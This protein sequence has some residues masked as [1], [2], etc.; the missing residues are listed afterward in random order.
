LFLVTGAIIA[1][2]Q[3]LPYI[4]GYQLANAFLVIASVALG[5]TVLATTGRGIIAK[6]AGLAYLAGIIFLMWDHTWVPAVLSIMAGSVM[7]GVGSL[8]EGKPRRWIGAL[9][10]LLG[11]AVW[12]VFPAEDELSLGLIVAGY[13]AVAAGLA[14]SGGGSMRPIA[15]GL[16]VTGIVAGLIVTATLATS[17]ATV[18]EGSS[19]QCG[20]VEAAVCLAAVDAVTAKVR[21]L[22]PADRIAYAFVDDQGASVCTQP[23]PMA[24]GSRGTYDAGWIDGIG[25]DPTLGIWAGLGAAVDSDVGQYVQVCWRLT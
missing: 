17:S 24:D 15:A 19:V 12:V 1:T 2:Q 10:L 13:A 11:V 6:L 3:W 18:H 22:R 4:V 8:I 25:T 20:S 21:A 16:A 23:P 5:L 14:R 7:L 9:A